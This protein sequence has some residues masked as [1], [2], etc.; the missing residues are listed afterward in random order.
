MVVPIVLLVFSAL[1]IAT[2]AVGIVRRKRVA[3]DNRA[4]ITALSAG[5]AGASAAEGA[6]PRG[7]AVLGAASVVVGSIVLVVDVLVMAGV[8]PL[9]R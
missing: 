3:R 5:S 9:P 8:L 7:I 1:C 4:R 2:G 6:T